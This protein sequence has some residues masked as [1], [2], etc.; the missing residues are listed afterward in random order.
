MTRRSSFPRQSRYS[1]AGSECG[2]RVGLEILPDFVGAVVR[3]A[4]IYHCQTEIIMGAV[5]KQRVETRLGSARK[6]AV[7]EQDESI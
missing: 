2:H 6:L 3:R 4:V 5:S 1:L 7:T